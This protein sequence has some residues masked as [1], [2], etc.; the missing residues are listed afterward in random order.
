MTLP[1]TLMFLDTNLVSH[2]TKIL[3]DGE[4]GWSPMENRR[5]GKSITAIAVQIQ[6]FRLKNLISS[7]YTAED[8][9]HLVILKARLHERSSAQETNAMWHVAERN[10]T[11]VFETVRRSEQA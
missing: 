1:F 5:V 8:L 7:A 9:I 4:G 10:F 3:V 11:R 2:G 6:D